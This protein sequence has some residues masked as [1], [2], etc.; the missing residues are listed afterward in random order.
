MIAVKETK[1][2]RAGRGRVIGVLSDTWYVI[3]KKE[4][5]LGEN[6]EIFDER[7]RNP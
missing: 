5:V 6:L 7:P 3:L 4:V 1:I 2:Q